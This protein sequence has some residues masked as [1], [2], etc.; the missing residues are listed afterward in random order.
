MK[1][2]ERVLWNSVKGL[3]SSDLMTLGRVSSFNLHTDPKRLAFV[4]SRYK[5]AAKM[6]S[7]NKNILELGC[8]EGIGVPILSEFALR[9][10]GVDQDSEAIAFAKRNWASQKNCFLADNFLGKKYGAFDSVISLD[11]VEHIPPKD[12]Q[13]FFKTVYDNIGD[14]GIGII[15][16]PNE[17]ASAYASRGSRIGHVNL[18]D[19]ERLQEQMRRLF[20]NV[21][22]FGVNDEVVH[23]GFSKMCHYLICV[24][25]YKRPGIMA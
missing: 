17:A 7:K 22:I 6:A 9:Y 5:F 20:Y 19:A 4:L 8:S 12:E 23:T 15:G 2:S 25:C 16:T 14:D 13:L 24:G 1:K 11:V 18:F 10:T 3:M 21:F